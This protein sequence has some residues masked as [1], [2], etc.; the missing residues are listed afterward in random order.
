M[1]TIKQAKMLAIEK[2]RSISENRYN[3]GKTVYFMKITIKMY[4]WNC[5]PTLKYLYEFIY[6]YLSY[7]KYKIVPICNLTIYS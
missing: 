2:K 5:M 6:F 4:Q 1:C 3:V 7:I